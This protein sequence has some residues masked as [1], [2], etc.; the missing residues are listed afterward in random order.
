MSGLLAPMPW[1]RKAACSGADPDLFFPRLG[2]D[3]KAQ[4][5][6]AKE[7]CAGCPVRVE[8][9]EYALVTPQK[10]GVW[11]GTTEKERIRIRRARRR[12]ERAAGAA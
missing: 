1:A 11:G 10:H 5:R 3:A 4:A 6:A 9:L 7:I 12:E 8:C 2:N